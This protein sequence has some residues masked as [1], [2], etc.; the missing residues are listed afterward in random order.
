MPAAVAIP[1]IIG[2]AGSIGS[3]YIASRQASKAT[4]AETQAGQEALGLQR[5]IYNQTRGDLS[6][7][8]QA[9][10]SALGQQMAL[11]GLPAGALSTVADGLQTTSGAIGGPPPTQN[12]VPTGSSA[13][14][15]LNDQGQYVPVNP[16]VVVPPGSSYDQFQNRSLYSGPD[17]PTL[18][19]RTPDG[20]M[21]SVPADKA[22]DFEANGGTIVGG[23]RG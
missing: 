1:A 16:N 12:D 10:V 5:D 11:L 3:A 4:Q 15:R 8:R 19:G 9:G 14:M 18:Q 23:G 21:V 13:G 6:P 7:Y 17:I 20:R 22:G 2:A